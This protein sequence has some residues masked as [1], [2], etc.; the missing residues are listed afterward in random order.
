MLLGKEGMYVSF[1]SRLHMQGS[2]MAD[3]RIACLIVKGLMFLNPLLFGLCRLSR[4]PDLLP[5]DKHL[6][7]ERVLTKLVWCGTEGQ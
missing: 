3:D 1:S 2:S 4:P 5:D 6:E 7:A